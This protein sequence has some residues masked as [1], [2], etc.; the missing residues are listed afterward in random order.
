MITEQDLRAAIAECEGE[1]NPTANTCIKLAAFYTI[2][3]HMY[4]GQGGDLATAPVLP[5]MSHSAPPET[6]DGIQYGNSDFAAVVQE[7]G[8]AAAWASI[9][10]LVDTVATIVPRL[11][12]G[13]MRR[14]G[15]L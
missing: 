7:K 2:Y 4:R 5:A 6:S 10:E 12:D 15:D 3:D 11:Y 9:E 13:F 14:L 8:I 1:R